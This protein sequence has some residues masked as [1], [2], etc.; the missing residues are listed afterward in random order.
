M[1]DKAD[2]ELYRHLP[3][4]P[5]EHFCAY[6]VLAVAKLARQWNPLAR[7]GLALIIVHRE[8]DR[9]QPVVISPLGLF[10]FRH[11]FTLL[12]INPNPTS[13]I[14]HAPGSGTVRFFGQSSRS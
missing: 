3:T 2:G 8:G 6:E 1:L 5:I 7:F 12:T 4:F 14:P 9:R 10:Q 13:I 11:R